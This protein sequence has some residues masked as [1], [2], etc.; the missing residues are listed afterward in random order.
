MLLIISP[1]LAIVV[2]LA[3]LAT[4]SIDILAAGRAYVEGE[5]LW[6][7]S[8]K[9]AVFYLLR[10]AQTRS[11]SDFHNY[12][13]AMKVPL[14][15]RQAR[16][17]LEKRRPNY[18]AVREGFLAGGT[19]PDDIPGV[20]GL[21]ERFAQV[22]YMQSVL[23]IWRTGDAF[24]ARLEAAGDRLHLLYTSDTAEPEAREEVLS[25][26]I[27]VN[28][29]LR[30]W[31]HRFSS[32]LGDATRWIQSTLMVV[33][34][35]VTGAL[36]PVGVVLTQRMV[37]RVDRAERELKEL[38]LRQ[39][40]AAKL[41]YHA[42]HDPLTNLLNRLEFENR[43]RQ[44]LETVAA[45]GRQHVVM[46]LD[47]DQ[48]KIVNDTCGHA[49]GDRLLRQ[50]SMLLTQKVRDSDSLARIGGDEFGVLLEN[51]PMQD[52]IR[53][54]DEL[55]RCIAD[56]RFVNDDRSF[57]IGASIGVVQ[58]ADSTLNLT[59]VLGA[60]DA[61]C[62][63]AKEK[64]RNR[65][66]Y[67]RPHDSDV[68]L[69]RGEMEW[70]SR[71][72]RA[73]QEGRFVLYAQRIMSVAG[74]SPLENHQELLVRMLDEH[75]RIVLPMAF[76]P[77][78]ERY[79]LMPSIDQWVI[80]RAFATINSFGEVIGTYAINVSG[81]SIADERF[82]EF[83]REQ[84]RHYRMPPRSICFEI[85]ETAAIANFDKA[86]RFFGEMKS[87][88]CLFSLDD[89]GAGMSSFGYLK[90]L[91]VDFIKIDGSFVKNVAHDEVDRATVQA[92]NDVGH[93]MGKKTIGEFVDGEMGLIALR[94]IGVDFAQGDWISP[95]APFVAKTAATAKA[96][97]VPAAAAAA[98]AI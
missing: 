33:L 32:T 42:S 38:K 44:A 88:G 9:D 80:Q 97:A 29:E 56:F 45:Q 6:S 95:P 37:S 63:M 94:E 1:F 2:V 20:I 18:A 96:I 47:L 40:Y 77:A 5:S 19:H 65:V 90:H 69:R 84:F 86:A 8:Q 21:Y 16:L 36:V 91:P 22:S 76:I 75:G 11:E 87:L 7:K 64:G 30:P 10:F 48:F 39:E 83:V 57:T 46:Y 98:A 72:Q 27:Q 3:W 54:A 50:V 81:K 93:V 66:Q 13:K 31:Q 34:L 52:A 51:C 25:R 41:A 61:A 67:Y 73:L 89:F 82:L 55:R 59:E 79:S 78:A 17:E 4:E 14:G 71:L 68:S 24:I 53:I 23:E 60:A 43:L 35:A 26:I 85:T 49:A 28:E 58:V 15:F 92:I 70:A 62:Y 74:A 12:E